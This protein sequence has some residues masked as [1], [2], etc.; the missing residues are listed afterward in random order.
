MIVGS[1]IN[2]H[3]ILDLLPKTSIVRQFQHEGF[4][5]YSTD[6]MTPASFDKDMTLQRYSEQYL[7]NAVKKIQNLSGEK[8]ISIFGYCWG[9]IFSLIYSATYPE[10]VKNLVLHATPV[11]LEESP[12][13]IEIWTK[14]MNVD[15]LVEVFGNIPGPFLNIAFLMRNPIEAYLKY[16]RFYSE[17]R[18]TDEIMTFF[19]VENWLYDS[20]PIIGLVFREIV[21]N[22]YKKNLLIKN[23]M[24]IDDNMIDLKKIT[25]PFLNIVGEK[26]DLVPPQSSKP[27]NSVIGS[28]DKKLIEFPSGHVGLCISSRAHEELWPKVVRWLAEHSQ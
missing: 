5:V 1:L 18:T 26:D 2:R 3:Y 27:V 23:Q 10:N 7:E 12:T 8:K 11:D 6:W 25:M 14:K 21:N 13:A 24:Y 20:R 19:S 17:P 15:K 28:K 16:F 22:I 9:G 4:D